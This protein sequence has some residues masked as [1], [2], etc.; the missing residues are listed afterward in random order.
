MGLFDWY[1]FIR[2]KGYTP[3]RLYRSVLMSI[4]ASGRRRLDVLGSCYK[5][6]RS[7]YCNMSQDAAHRSLEK[8]V[9]RFGTALNMTLYI[10]GDPAKEKAETAAER[11]KRREKALEQ[12]ATSLTTLESRI[13]NNQGLRKRHFVDVRSGIASSF[14]WSMESR[15]S[16]ADYMA[17]RHWT[18]SVVA[19]EADLAIAID[20]NPRDIIISCDSD[21]LAY[22]SIVTLWRPVSNGMILVYSIP[23]LLLTLGITR[24]QLTA[25]A[26]VSRNDYNKNIRC[27]GP[28][29][30]F[31]IIKSIDSLDPKEVVHSYLADTRVISRNKDKKE[32]EDS[33]RVFIDKR[34]TKL[35]RVDSTS[36][37][38]ILYEQLR[39][40]FKN[41]CTRHNELKRIRMQELRPRAT[42]D[43]IVRLR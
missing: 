10:D 24:A 28:A 14:Y 18:V 20:A 33:I 42:S 27:L 19:T 35:D 23:D 15:R 34:Q 17:E 7:S 36:N 30:N 5:V 16:F 6:I 40:H 25:L 2:R 9:S 43:E 3:F 37:A 39:L 13:D 8:E 31:S 41:L 22:E 4:T 26:V 38:P 1:P 29:T 12:T 21:M 32:F 11:Q